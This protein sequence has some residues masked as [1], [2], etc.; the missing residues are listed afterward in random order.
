MQ[1]KLPSE[2]PE[3]NLSSVMLF[4]PEFAVIILSGFLFVIGIANR[5][6]HPSF[7]D[8]D[9]SADRAWRREHDR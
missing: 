1:Q 6:R 3:G 5:R 2:R 4:S 7:N 9:N 8:S